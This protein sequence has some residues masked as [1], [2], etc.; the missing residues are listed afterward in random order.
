MVEKRLEVTDPKSFHLYVAPEFHSENEFTIDDQTFA[1]KWLEEFGAEN[2]EHLVGKFSFV[3]AVYQKKIIPPD[4]RGTNSSTP[5]RR[6]YEKS[7]STLVQTPRRGFIVEKGRMS[8]LFVRWQKSG[9][10]E[11]WR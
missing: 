5:T 8:P 2:V 6:G 4:R 9:G 1:F 11:S 7:G 10:S 3:E